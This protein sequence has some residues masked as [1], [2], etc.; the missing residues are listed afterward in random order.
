[1]SAYLRLPT[2]IDG[3]D[4]LLNGGLRFPRDGSIFTVILGGPGTG[5]THLALELAVRMLKSPA[6]GAA[7]PLGRGACHVFYS[8]DQSPSELHAKLREDFDFYGMQGDWRRIVG[9]IESDDHAAQIHEFKPAAPGSER[10]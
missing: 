9:T 10:Y 7:E 2:D 4:L 8:L 3:L 1:M 6:E 5:K